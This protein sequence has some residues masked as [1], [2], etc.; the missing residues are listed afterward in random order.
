MKRSEVLHYKL[1]LLKLCAGQLSNK[2]RPYFAG[3][4]WLALWILCMY[5]SAQL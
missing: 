1:A 2:A 3:A 4:A 5:G